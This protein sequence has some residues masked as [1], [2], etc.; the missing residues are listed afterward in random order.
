MS[1]SLTKYNGSLANIVDKGELPLP[2]ETNIYLQTVL[3]AGINYYI[4]ES[5]TLLEGEKIILKREPE[6]KYDKYAIELYTEKNKKIGYV[7]KRN[8][9]IF[10][11]LMDAGK[12]LYAEIRTINYYFEEIEEIWIRIFLKDI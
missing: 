5:I 4:E 9:K 3:I 11:R 1:S 6:N 10:A 8:N 7:S 12:I 2:F